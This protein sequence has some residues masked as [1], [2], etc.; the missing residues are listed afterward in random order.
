[1]NSVKLFSHFHSPATATVDYRRQ[2]SQRKGEEMVA[3]ARWKRQRDGGRR[4]GGGV[5][6]GNEL[7]VAAATFGWVHTH[8][9]RLGECLLILRSGP[10]GTGL[11]HSQVCEHWMGF[12]VHE[13][14]FLII[15]SL[16]NPSCL[17]RMPRKTLF[18]V[19]LIYSTERE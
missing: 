17:C 12:N 5:S 16:A 14:E 10:Q 4:E 11:S 9:D 2:T 18:G 6:A 1:M 7:L 3:F 13:D 8:S 15:S 19:L